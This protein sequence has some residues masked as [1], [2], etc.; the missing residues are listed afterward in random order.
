MPPPTGRS[1]F[2]VKPVPAL[3][4]M[5][6]PT[7]RSPR[8]GKAAPVP[9]RSHMPP[10][11]YRSIADAGLVANDAPA[12]RAVTLMARAN[13]RFADENIVILLGW[14]GQSGPMFPRT[15]APGFFSGGFLRQETAF[16]ALA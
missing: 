9:A 15:D 12:S 4:Y 16:P 13:L 14:G 10:P 6:P 1:P 3:S 2:G 8:P 5:P 11:T 7:G